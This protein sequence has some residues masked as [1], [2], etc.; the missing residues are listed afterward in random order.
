[1]TVNL[2]TCVPGQ[3]VKD[4]SGHVLRYVAHIPKERYYKHALYDLDE[5]SCDYFTDDGLYYIT[6]PNSPCN[7]VEI[8]P[9]NKPEIPEPC[10]HTSI[11]WWESCPWITDRLPTLNDVPQG[12]CNKNYVLLWRSD[13]IRTAHY[14]KV[15]RDDRW[16]HIQEPKKHKQTIKEKALAL[17][18]KDKDGWVPT[19][20]DW[21]IIREGLTE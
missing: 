21:D 8:L 15:T 9:L 4:K 11:T 2:N 5:E 7:I 20:N 10:K 13:D 14:L 19:P 3:L 12:G 6:I 18:A 16:I 17:L 1:M